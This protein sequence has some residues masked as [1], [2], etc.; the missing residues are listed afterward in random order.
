[1]SQTETRGW[2]PSCKSLDTFCG[3]LKWQFLRLS[4]VSRTCTFFPLTLSLFWSSFFFSSLLWRFPSLLFTCPYRRKFDFSTS[5][6]YILYIH[7]Y[8]HSIVNISPIQLQRLKIR[9]YEIIILRLFGYPARVA[10]RGKDGFKKVS[11]ARMQLA[12]QFHGVRMPFFTGN[13]C[14]FLKSWNWN[15]G[16][17][18]N[19]TPSGYW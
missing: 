4:Y 2:C 16:Y 17:S 6:R 10:T 1:M 11:T 18:C 13:V 12:H 15:I 3:A 7:R 19:Y 5:F 8:T 9:D 14:V